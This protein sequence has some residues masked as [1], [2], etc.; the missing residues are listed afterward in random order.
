MSYYW[1]KNILFWRQRHLLKVRC[2]NRCHFEL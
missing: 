2:W 1:S